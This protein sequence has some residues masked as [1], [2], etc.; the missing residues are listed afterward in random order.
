MSIIEQ[1]EALQRKIKLGLRRYLAP[2]APKASSWVFDTSGSA[3][4]GG[5]LFK[6]I[7]G[8][9]TDGVVVFTRGEERINL[10]YHAAGLGIGFLGPPVSAT[11]S[12]MSAPNAGTTLYI[13]PGNDDFDSVA[14]FM[15]PGMTQ[16]PLIMFCGDAGLAYEG[17]YC[18]ML[19][20]VDPA[21]V[22][23]LKRLARHTHAL[24]TIVGQKS[25]GFW[26]S[27]S[28]TAHQEW[29][30]AKIDA[31]VTILLAQVAWRGLS[32]S[33]RGQLAIFGMQAG[34]A[35]GIGL[36]AYFGAVHDIAAENIPGYLRGIR[37]PDEPEALPPEVER[38]MY[39][40]VG[41]GLEVENWDWARR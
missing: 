15:V 37:Q 16:G 24:Q 29:D 27:V 34:F 9:L 32:G 3:S 35:S 6:I 10:R 28:Q 25:Q 18:Q 22:G 23:N 20:G 14:D 19:L 7:S 17:T 21:L 31:D 8:S 39:T 2:P 38:Q 4:A 11:W 33:I 12:P 1:A 5:G 40:P 30:I 13:M 26:D 41:D 36:T